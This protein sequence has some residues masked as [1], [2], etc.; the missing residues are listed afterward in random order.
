MSPNEA[1]LH[2]YWDVLR[3]NQIELIC[4]FN[5]RHASKEPEMIFINNDVVIKDGGNTKK[6]NSK[7]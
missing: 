7:I 5:I 1:M 2:K 6:G 3:K 4:K